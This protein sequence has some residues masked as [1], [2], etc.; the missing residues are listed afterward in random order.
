[1][2]DEA[3]AQATH[4]AAHCTLSKLKADGGTISS[5]AFPKNISTISRSQQQPHSQKRNDTHS[6]TSTHTR[7]HTHS[8]KD[9]S[10]YSNAATHSQQHRRK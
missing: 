9:S 7:N 5:R 1:M 2:F 3:L 8:S 4:T 6:L 10:A